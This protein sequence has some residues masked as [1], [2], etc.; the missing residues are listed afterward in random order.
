M[1]PWSKGQFVISHIF[2]QKLGNKL[3][4]GRRLWDHCPQRPALPMEPYTDGDDGDG[5]KAGNPMFYW[6]RDQSRIQLRL[7]CRTWNQIILAMAKEL[8]VEM[9]VDESLKTL[10]ALEEVRMQRIGGFSSSGAGTIQVSTA[11][12]GSS[13]RRS[14]RIAAAFSSRLTSSN[15][16]ATYA[17]QDVSSPSTSSYSHLED[18]AMQYGV[19]SD[20]HPR[21]YQRIM[22]AQSDKRRAINQTPIPLQAFYN[23]RSTLNQQ[24]AADAHISSKIRENNPWSCPPSI[25]SLHVYGA[26]PKSSHPQENE[27]L[28]PGSSAA[29]SSA[30]GGSFH[31]SSGCP[32]YLIKVDDHGTA[33]DHWLRAAVPRHLIKFSINC[34]R[35][36]GLSGSLKSLEINR[37]LK[38]T[39]GVLLFGFRRLE[40]LTTLAMCSDQLFVDESFAAALGTLVHLRCL[41]Y[42]FP[43]DP[44]QPAWRDLFRYCTSCELYHRVTATKKYTRQ[45][46]MPQLPNQI[47]DFTFAMDEIQF[48]KIRV[49]P[50][51]QYRRSLSRTENTRFCLV[52][53][54]TQYK[55]GKSDQVNSRPNAW[56][57]FDLASAA[58][59]SWWPENLTRLD[60][61]NC[62]VMDA[63]FDVPPQLRELIIGYPLLPNELEE[64][65]QD[66]NLD[67]LS[68]QWLPDTLLSLEVHAVPYHV[69][70]EM[71]DEPE[72]KV[73]AWMA[74]S[75]NILG[76]VPSQ[77]EQFTLHSFQ[78]PDADAL[79]L[80]AAR[81][82][83]SLETWTLRLLCP[84]RPRR[85][86]FTPM[87]LY[88]P[89][90]FVDEDSSDDDLFD[91]DSANSDG[92][93]YDQFNAARIQR[94]LARNARWD[95]TVAAEADIQDMYDETPIR[96]RDS[97]KK[98]RALRR[99]NVD[100]NSQHHKYCTSRW[101]GNM[102]LS[103]PSD[104]VLDEFHPQLESRHD[105]LRAQPTS[106][107]CPSKGK[108]RADKMEN[109]TSSHGKLKSKMADVSQDNP[110]EE[111]VMCG[112]GGVQK[113]DS[114]Q[115]I[116]NTVYTNVQQGLLK[117]EIRYWHNSCC[118]KRCLGW[119]RVRQD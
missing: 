74:Y 55:N 118:G 36:F 35:D 50:Q 93:G 106:P 24:V 56:C 108:S 7:V 63:K 51:D 30:G 117:T 52:L 84:Q 40:N 91:S 113:T 79:S 28:V 77:L 94:R 31:D 13:V 19:Y 95:H 99:L 16:T 15:T 17:S 67:E 54:K 72:R 22:Q 10:K 82:E 107:S 53:W 97:C 103:E 105:S 89:V 4:A 42:T 102:G 49:D 114:V 109:W 57:G 2:D 58:V 12:T 68:R 20:R 18:G 1:S 112:E 80:M 71:Q 9:G 65:V 100:V 29:G 115:I 59:R 23:V 111:F 76:M 39:G 81:V 98:L 37:C 70:C 83:T 90:V 46:L 92:E 116:M 14:A 41:R 45:L 96:I 87:Q 86:G 5:P 8:H 25:S 78:V 69:S 85:S 119:I 33:L 26:P 88:S 64:S 6:Y 32:E 104:R 75:E 62:T 44:V 34:S 61:S 3:V 66:P 110:T 101:K 47:T 43:C 60:L 73:K 21:L 48:Q 11:R 27:M 38:V